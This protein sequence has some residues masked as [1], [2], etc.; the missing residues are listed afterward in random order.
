MDYPQLSVLKTGYKMTLRNRVTKLEKQQP[1]TVSIEEITEYNIRNRKRIAMKQITILFVLSVLFLVSCQ[2]SEGI[3][4]TAIAQTQA[5]QPT[6]TELP[7]STPIPT[8]SASPRATLP[9][10]PTPLLMDPFS[11]LDML[12]DAIGSSDKN[13]STDI[14]LLDAEYQGADIRNPETLSIKIQDNLKAYNGGCMV[15]L[16]IIFSGLKK[17]YPRNLYPA[18]IE[19]LSV[20]CY[21]RSSSLL[22]SYQVSFDDMLYFSTLEGEALYNAINERVKVIENNLGGLPMLTLETSQTSGSA[23][24]SAPFIALCKDRTYSYSQSRRGACR[25]HGGVKKWIREGNR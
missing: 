5:A 22:L 2:P 17:A 11:V 15:P 21:T 24:A 9:P 20:E 8:A 7:T 23:S 16:V 13:S 4:Q 10:T 6:A 14:E 12:N 18:S 19:N 25:G 1:P 3:I